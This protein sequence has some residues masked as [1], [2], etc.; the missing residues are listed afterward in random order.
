MKSPRLRCPSTL[1]KLPEG[2]LE[3]LSE[4]QKLAIVSRH[5]VTGATVLT[6]DL[7]SYSTSVETFGGENIT[8]IRRRDMVFISYMGDYFPVITPDVMASNGVIH[9]IDKVILPPVAPPP[10][11]TLPPPSTPTPTP[12]PTPTTVAPTP[13]PILPGLN[14]CIP[15]LSESGGRLAKPIAQV[16]D[17]Y[18][19]GQSTFLK[20][21]YWVR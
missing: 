13:T 1:H 17:Y 12:P 11:P 2:I 19:D 3:N 7:T 10:T 9:V 20:N 6:D 14:L 18:I 16:K 5:F 21:V 15:T 8:L 4:E